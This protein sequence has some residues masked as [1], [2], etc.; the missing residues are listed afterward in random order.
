MWESECKGTVNGQIERDAPCYYETST[1]YATTH[2]RPHRIAATG[3]RCTATSTAS[4][5]EVYTW[6]DANDL[7]DCAR[8]ADLSLN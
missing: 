8:T 4:G 2:E 7:R 5:D 6:G 3:G 1:I